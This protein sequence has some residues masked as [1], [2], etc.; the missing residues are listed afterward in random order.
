MKTLI[1]LIIVFILSISNL[2]SQE[3]QQEILIVGTMHTVPKI[4]KNSYKPMLR[5]AKKYKPEAIYVESPM[6]NDSISWEYLKKVGLKDIKNFTNYQILYKRL[7][8]ITTLNLT[9]LLEK[10]FQV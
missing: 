9:L 6:A 10:I 7:L 5:F 1:T 8:I 4:V 2:S 3:N